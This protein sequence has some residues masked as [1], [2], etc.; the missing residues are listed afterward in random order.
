MTTSTILAWCG[1]VLGLGRTVPQLLVVRRAHALDGLSINSC[2]GL[3]LSM[4]WWDIYAV[5]IMDV[6][7][8][9]SSVGASVAPVLTWAI[10]M[11]RGLTSNAQSAAI[12][13]GAALGASSLI[14][15]AG[16]VGLLASGSTV[17][18]TVPQF[19]R[20]V[21]TRD[22]RG[23]STVTWALTAVNTSIWAAYGIREHLLPT[24]LPALLLL[25]TAGLVLGLKARTRWRRSDAPTDLAGVIHG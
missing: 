2:M 1:T 19:W 20:L 16:F 9:V 12:L 13:V 6:P 11:R 17:L 4:L 22:V 15:G 14:T 23:V 24:V 10:L 21:R 8:M 7:L 18:Y 25:P 3:V 5:G